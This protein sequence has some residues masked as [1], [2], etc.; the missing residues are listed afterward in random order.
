MQE[1]RERLERPLEEERIERLRSGR[2]WTPSARRASGVGCL[3]DD[4]EA[5][6]AKN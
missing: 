3:V 5:C 1:E 4:P 2:N 6:K